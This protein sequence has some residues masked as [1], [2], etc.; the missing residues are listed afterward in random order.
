MHEL[1]CITSIPL[2][3]KPTKQKTNI[4]SYRGHTVQTNIYVPQQ[5]KIQIQRWLNSMTLY[6]RIPMSITAVTSSHHVFIFKYISNINYFS[7]CPSLK[8]IHTN[9]QCNWQWHTLK[10]PP[11][12]RSA[13]HILVGISLC[14]I[15][16]HIWSIW[17]NMFT[18]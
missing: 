8:H 16:S 10:F 12:N 5:S 11:E 14:V 3:F 13:M 1:D 17:G 6:S 18:F 4:G 7:L 9:I 15:F 2:I